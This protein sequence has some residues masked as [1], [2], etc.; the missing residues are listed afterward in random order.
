[1]LFVAC[2]YV[3]L[4]IVLLVGLFL[5]RWVPLISAIIFRD[6]THLKEDILESGLCKEKLAK[7][8]SDQVG[9]HFQIIKRWRAQAPVEDPD[10]DKVVEDLFREISQ[11]DPCRPQK[12]QHNQYLRICSMR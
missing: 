10:F 2:V 9:P 11:E 3:V 12:C 8:G 6:K 1:M 5:D 4:F 7:S